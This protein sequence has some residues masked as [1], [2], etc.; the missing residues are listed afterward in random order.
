MRD[1]FMPQN[2]NK[3]NKFITII[4]LLNRFRGPTQNT[5]TKHGTRQKCGVSEGQL[6]RQDL[7][8]PKLL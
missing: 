5:T 7:L 6:I 2:F 1:P 3:R 8:H 4:Y